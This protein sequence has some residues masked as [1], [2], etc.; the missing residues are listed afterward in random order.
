MARKT[1][2]KIPGL[3]AWIDNIKNELSENAARDIVID[4]KIAGPY[5]SGEFEAN[6]VVKRGATGVGATKKSSFEA[7]P[8]QQPRTITDITIPPATGRGDITYSI[9]NQMEYR[10]IALDLVPDSKGKL[11]GDKPRR[12]ADKYWYDTYV[13]TQLRG[14]LEQ[15]TGK[16]ARLP[17][18]K[19]FRGR[20]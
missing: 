12:T 17:K 3:N 8:E 11:R 5:W 19:N 1:N 13:Q 6:W 9:A 10:D 14:R 7:F 18:I 16:V 2:I 4:L 15:T 20:G